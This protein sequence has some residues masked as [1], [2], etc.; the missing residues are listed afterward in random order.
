M[1]KTIFSFHVFLVVAAL[2]PSV[3]MAQAES[4]SIGSVSEHKSVTAVEVKGNR[5]VSL[6]N[7]LAKIK[8]RVG[9]EY[10]QNVI[11]DDL[12]RLYNTGFFSD[13]RV[14][15]EDF[16]N[17]FRVIFYVE[18]KPVIE[19]ISFSRLKYYKPR[20]LL[21]K[22]RLKEGKFLDNKSLQDDIKTIEELYEKKGLTLVN[23][24]V[25]KDIDPV[26]NKAKLHFIIK[27]GQRVKIKDIVFKGNESFSKKR[28]LKVIKTRKDGLFNSGYLKERVIEEDLQRL[29]AFYEKEGFIDATV[30]YELETYRSGRVKVVIDIKEDK[31]YYVDNVSVTGNK[32]F[33]NEKILSQMQEIKPGN[34]FSR[35]RLSL[36]L[37]N[38]RSIYFDEGYIFANIQETLA[39][40]PD[41]GRVDVRLDIHE[42]DP[43]YVNKIKIQGNTRTRDIVIRRELRLFPGDK[44][45]GSKLRRSKERLTNLGYFNDVAYDTEDTSSPN[46]KNL[47]VQVEE[48][49]TGSFN[50]GGGYST[51]DN[52]VGFAEIEQKNFDFTN[53][54]T[55]TGG[56]QHLVFR[57]ESSA[58]R[59]NFRLSFTEPWIMDY[60]VSGG[61]DLYLTERDRERDVGYAFDEA[62]KGGKIRFGKQLSE[63][64][65]SG[66]YYRL[67]NIK[68]DNFE[69]DVSSE[70]LR[71]EGENNLSVVG[72][73]LTRDER[74]NVFNPTKGLYLNGGVDVAG[75]PFAGDKDFYRLTS[76]A[77]YYVPLKYYKSV[78]E[79]G[80][81]TGV[82]NDYGSS[83]FVPIF[84][85]FFAGGSRSIRGYDERKVGPLDPVTNDPIGG[86]SMIVG[87]IELTVPVFEFMKLAA[88]YDTGNVWKDIEDI[89]STAFK[90]GVGMGLRFKTPIG[91]INLDYGYPL[92]DEPGEESRSG[93]FYFSVS[94]GF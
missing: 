87:N 57:T 9:Q 25:E 3:A 23:I 24:R 51:V 20:H 49:K 8:T 53:W 7:I 66:I 86:E 14:D 26:T 82:M 90:S 69:D 61:F 38:V 13:V 36:D 67:E 80:L 32:V 37:S 88:F 5:T 50:F 11:S 43:A 75:G 93:K 40:N 45:D 30:N 85:R 15:R 71:E 63:Y 58:T 77:T 34:I 33:D 22:M 35:D 84:E 89:G 18:E 42:G 55:F 10:M 73:T 74:D 68:I 56:G 2:T 27:E 78:L 6:S 52:L 19:K 21:N 31:R 64:V 47:I 12:K 4:K 79:F 94:R 72:L 76:Q 41:T 92:D 59:N 65:D 54:P 81:R 29:K 62:R 39:I 16:D 48:A 91:P 1:I 70:I 46:H 44:F 83:D 60:P 17:G 28:L